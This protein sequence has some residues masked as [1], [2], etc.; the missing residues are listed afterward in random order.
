MPSL[1]LSNIDYDVEHIEGL[2]MRW[3]HVIP[4]TESGVERG[5]EVIRKR[6]HREM[7]HSR[8][9]AE[10]QFCET[11]FSSPS[12]TCSHIWSDF[13]PFWWVL[14]GCALKGFRDNVRPFGSSWL[15]LACS[16]ALFLV[17]CF[18]LCDSIFAPELSFLSLSLPPSSILTVTPTTLF[19]SEYK[20][21]CY[22]S[23]L[24]VTVSRPVCLASPLL[25]GTP[26]LLPSGLSSSCARLDFP[27][28]WTH[29]WVTFCR[30]L[31]PFGMCSFFIPKAVWYFILPY[32]KHTC[33]LGLFLAA[34]D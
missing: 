30:R 20:F 4:G 13:H 9:I 7:S 24:T 34:V 15:L 18:P 28:L 29:S 26:S 6:G 1:A 31:S 25:A 5:Q 23:A 14:K 16:F 10:S 19:L 11:L 17:L 21:S 8:F 27:S 2:V 12:Q 33:P 3:H 32:C 22:L